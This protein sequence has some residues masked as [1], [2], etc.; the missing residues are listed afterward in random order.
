M[1]KYDMVLDSELVGKGNKRYVLASKSK[2]L[3]NVLLDYFGIIIFLT[4]FFAILILIGGDEFVVSRHS[5]SEMTLKIQGVIAVICYYLFMEYYLEGKSFGK[6]ITGTKVVMLD[7]KA[8]SLKAV[9]GR[10]LARF[11]P[12]EPLS[13]LW[14]DTQAWHDKLSGTMVVEDR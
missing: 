6:F 2:R 7:G 13:L 4:V 14:A 5:S 10:V 9:F 12:F 3:L 1:A 8:P 11:I